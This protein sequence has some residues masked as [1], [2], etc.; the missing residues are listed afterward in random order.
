MSLLGVFSSSLMIALLM[1]CS[2]GMVCLGRILV[3]LRSLLMCLMCHSILFFRADEAREGSYTKSQ[4]SVESPEIEN[5]AAIWRA[6]D[7]IRCFGQDG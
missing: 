5:F 6:Q 3:M 7:L 1:M 2:S 4:P